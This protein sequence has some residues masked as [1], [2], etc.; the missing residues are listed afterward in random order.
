MAGASAGLGWLH[1]TDLHVGTES[2]HL[3]PDAEVQV[4]DDL[5]LLHELTGD[6]R[7]VFFTGDLVQS[8]ESGQY[9]KFEEIRE[10]IAAAISELQE[11]PI[12]LAVPGNHDLV[13]PGSDSLLLLAANQWQSQQSMRDA[14]WKKDSKHELHAGVTEALANWSSWWNDHQPQQVAAFRQGLLPGDYSATFEL[15]EGKVGVVGL[16]STFLQLDGGDFKGELAL[17]EHQLA[18][19]CPG[20]GTKWAREHD[21]TFLLTHQPPSWLD[22]PSKEELQQLAPPARFSVHLFGHQHESYGAVRSEFGGEDRVEVLGQSLFGLEF[23]T[24]G[25]NERKKREQGYSAGQVTIHPDSLG[26]RLWPRKG[27]RLGDGTWEIKPDDLWRLD[28]DKADEGTKVRVLARPGRSL[29]EQ[30]AR[31]RKRPDKIPTAE[32]ERRYREHAL[33]MWDIIDLANLP[34]D[35][36][37][38]T[39]QLDLRRLYVPLRLR[40]EF[41]PHSALGDTQFSELERRRAAARLQASYMRRS[42]EFEDVARMPV[43]KCLGRERR[44]VVLGDPGA[45]KT[46]LLRWIA[47]AYLL[48]LTSDPDLGKLPDVKTLPRDDWLPVIIR[49]RDL[50][51]TQMDELK[52]MLHHSLRRDEFIEAKNDPIVGML[53]ERLRNG[54]ALL[55]VDGLDEIPALTVRKKFCKQLSSIARAY[56]KTPIIVTSRIVGYREIGRPLWHA[57]E[58]FTVADLS[59]ADKNEFARRWIALTEIES[60]QRKATRDLTRDIHS[61]DAIERLTANPMLLTTLALVKR[62][63]GTLPRRRAEL[64]SSAVNVL[65]NWRSDMGKML[66]QREALPQLEYLAYAMC[67]Q[68]VTH[69]SEDKTVALLSQMRTEYGDRIHDLKGHKPDDFLQLVE[70]QT[71]ILLQAGH[72]K[73]GGRLV[74]VFEF[75]HLSFQEY[76]AGMALVEGRH[77]SRD[78]KKTLPDRVA[79]VAVRAASRDGSADGDSLEAAERW[80]EALRLCAVSCSDD[81]VDGVLRAILTPTEQETAWSRAILAALCLADDPNASDAV[82]DAVLRALVDRDADDWLGAPWTAEWPNTEKAVRELASSHWS[83]RLRTLV[84]NRFRE[85]AAT[86]DRLEQLAWVAATLANEMAP[87]A[88]Q[89]DHW[90]HACAGHLSSNDTRA[91]G[92]A[93]SIRGLD[94]WM[95]CLVGPELIGALSDALTRSERRALTA[96]WALA[97]LTQQDPNE[98]WRDPRAPSSL[99]AAAAESLVDALGV[100]GE[101]VKRSVAEVLGS[102]GDARAVKPLINALGTEADAVKHSAAQALGNLGDARA[103]KPLINALSTETEEVKRSAAEALGNLGDARAV[104]PL[105]DA[106]STGSDAVKHLAAQALGNLGDAHAVKPLIDALSTGMDWWYLQVPLRTIHDTRAVKPLIDALGTGSDAVKRLAAEV[107]GNLGDARAVKPLIDA[108]STETEEVKR[109]A[110]RAL[111][112]LGDVPEV[113]LVKDVLSAEDCV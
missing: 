90:Q 50:K 31:R 99:L 85:P 96:A 86:R 56:P 6:W 84:S 55:L 12:W 110:A 94:R 13:R 87:D 97:F 40:A 81:E 27:K 4:L 62:Q 82:G 24:D 11:E 45:G 49:C 98:P 68:G 48:R 59:R 72:E 64:Y 92:A 102:L 80:R 39:K 33:R 52:S 1:L 16:N 14:F 17:S 113:A 73:Y 32:T 22:E 57:F 76:L 74:P 41:D 78:W 70:R 20:G 44:V 23:F 109:E 54:R 88:E 9:E 61:T 8:G 53:F 37:L 21:V 18:A 35:R 28:K 69:L 107:L 105:I 10:R 112:R 65:L 42:D 111:L 3:W 106:L 83:G 91:I 66:D 108:L 67:E 51:H 36:E 71:E 15:P 29:R 95:R 2:D 77:P 19:V 34:E 89:F 47:T 25:K 7:F 30:P 100:G 104:K 58:H 26:L 38:A 5:P 60:R 63:V 101:E 79:E 46:T 93:L 75:R 43:G 103:V